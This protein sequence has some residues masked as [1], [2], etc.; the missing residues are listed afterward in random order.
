MVGLVPKPIVSE[1]RRTTKVGTDLPSRP[2]RQKR[3]P[4][5]QTTDY[6]RPQKAVHRPDVGVQV[7]E[8]RQRI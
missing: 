7:G 1:N 2:P 3:A 6:Q 8:T 4:Q 5:E